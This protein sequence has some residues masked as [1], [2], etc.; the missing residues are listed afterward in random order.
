MTPKGNDVLIPIV[1]EAID[2][3][4]YGDN[5]NNGKGNVVVIEPDSNDSEEEAKDSV[6][7]DIE[8]LIEEDTKE[9][10]EEGYTNN[11]DGKIIE[12]KVEQSLPIDEEARK[13]TMSYSSLLKD[14][15]EIKGIGPD[16]Y[17]DHE[18]VRAFILLENKDI[19]FPFNLRGIHRV[20]LTV[21]L[22]KAEM[23]L[24]DFMPDLKKYANVKHEMQMAYDK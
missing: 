1:D 8:K 7:E 11:E 24:Y 18:F 19:I 21:S 4:Y 2:I 16:F 23:M 17:L 3:M 15:N 6:E 13:V 14:Y 10:Y 20:M 22:T 12:D 5:F 9:G